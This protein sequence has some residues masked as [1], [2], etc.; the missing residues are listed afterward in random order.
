LNLEELSLATPVLSAPLTGGDRSAGREPS[1][2]HDA[3]RWERYRLGVR[4]RLEKLLE[5]LGR[6]GGGL[7][8]LARVAEALAIQDAPKDEDSFRKE[9]LAHLW[10]SRAEHS[11]GYLMGLHAELCEEG[12]DRLADVIWDCVGQLFSLCLPLSVLTESLRQHDG[13]EFVLFQGTVATEVGAEAVLAV[14]DGK[15]PSILTH[16][17]GPRGKYWIPFEWP[18]PNG[19]SLEEEV[20][21]FL[22]HLRVQSK[23][24]LNEGMRRHQRDDVTAG[25]ALLSKVLRG[26]YGNRK[27]STGRTPYCTLALLKTYDDAE[28]KKSVLEQVRKLVPTLWFLELNPDS[29]A[30]EQEYSMIDCVNARSEWVGRRKPR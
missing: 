3:H 10:E 18:A 7:R 26:S 23:I 15:G 25:T 30:L 12:S 9:I 13:P 4:H 21:A 2:D 27:R 20:L 17:L 29:D 5:T 24:E 14:V 16:E 8:I 11:I 1:G 22:D 28:R 6:E 19:P